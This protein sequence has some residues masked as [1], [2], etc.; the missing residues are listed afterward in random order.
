MSRLCHD[1]EE[2]RRG[3]G[4]C[5]VHAVPSRLCQDISWQWCASGRFPGGGVQ[6]GRVVHVVAWRWLA[7]GG[8]VMR[9]YLYPAVVVQKHRSLRQPI[10]IV[11]YVPGVGKGWRARAVST[12]TCGRVGG[13]LLTAEGG[14]LLQEGRGFT[15]LVEGQAVRLLRALLPVH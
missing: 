8:R 11:D 1:C 5:A 10:V 13:G 4:Q 12:S 2:G 3:R 15:R 7:S 6:V 14:H 9:D